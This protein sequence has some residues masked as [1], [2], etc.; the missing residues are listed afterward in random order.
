MQPNADEDEKS[1]DPFSIDQRIYDVARKVME[2]KSE[3]LTKVISSSFIDHVLAS[4]MF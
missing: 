3:E 1:H 4:E 2:Q